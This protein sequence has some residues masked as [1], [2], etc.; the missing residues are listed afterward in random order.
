MLC[1]LE[2]LYE[3]SHSVLLFSLLIHWLEPCAAAS[4]FRSV[5]GCDLDPLRV[6]QNVDHGKE[7]SQQLLGM[8]H[9]RGLILINMQNA[10]DYLSH[11]QA[12][13]G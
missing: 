13:A 3:V 4:P 12:D 2:I 11:L 9:L 8:S 5:H 1:C 10:I 6:Y 7:L